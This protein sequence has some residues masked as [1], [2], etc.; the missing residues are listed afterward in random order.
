MRGVFGLDGQYGVEQGERVD[1]C[2]G[3]LDDAR[4]HD[5]SARHDDAT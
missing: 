4:R 2:A 5:Q 3:Q 1:H